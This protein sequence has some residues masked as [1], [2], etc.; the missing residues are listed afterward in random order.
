MFI[1]SQRFIIAT[2]YLNCQIAFTTD[3]VYAEP[4]KLWLK[5]NGCSTPFFFCYLDFCDFMQSWYCW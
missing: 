2:K 3:S 5:I 1:S 4:L